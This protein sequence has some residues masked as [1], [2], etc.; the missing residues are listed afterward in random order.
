M[1]KQFTAEDILNAKEV[2]FYNNDTLYIVDHDDEA[3]GY[4]KGCSGWYHKENFWDYFESKLMMT[5]FSH[6]NK[7]ELPRY[8]GIC[9]ATTNK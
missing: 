6:I 3:Y 2:H 4:S 5:Y 8:R 1:A 7:E 9:N